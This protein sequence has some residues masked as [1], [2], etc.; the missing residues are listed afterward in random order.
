MR[1]GPDHHGNG[2]GLNHDNGRGTSAPVTIRDTSIPPEQMPDDFG[3]VAAYGV[4]GRSA[5]T[6]SR[7]RSP[8]IFGLSEDRV[9]IKLG[10]SADVLDDLCTA[11]HDRGTVARVLRHLRARSGP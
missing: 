8:R 3:F 5:S 2:C 4:L 11:G 1:H 6:R 7:A 9:T 10:L